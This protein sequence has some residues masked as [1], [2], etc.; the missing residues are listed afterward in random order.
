MKT[1][2]LFLM[3]AS[4]AYA[5]P[6]FHVMRIRVSDGLVLERNQCSTADLSGVGAAHIA[7]IVYFDNLW[8]SQ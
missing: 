7:V 8:S 3:L 6:L 4:A 1:I 5:D 2:G